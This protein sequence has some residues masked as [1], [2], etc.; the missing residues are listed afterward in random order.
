MTTCIKQC[1]YKEDMFLA[2]FSYIS[3]LIKNN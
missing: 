3:K 1:H 2:K